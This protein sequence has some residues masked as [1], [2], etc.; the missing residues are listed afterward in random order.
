[1]KKRLSNDGLIKACYK[2]IS[3]SISI[4]KDMRT[5]SEVRSCKLMKQL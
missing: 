4:M 1:M 3:D 5:K 2:H